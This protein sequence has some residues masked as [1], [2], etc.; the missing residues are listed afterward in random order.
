MTVCQEEE[1]HGASPA[2]EE[3][4]TVSSLVGD[5]GAEGGGGTRRA[6]SPFLDAVM[7]DRLTHR[8]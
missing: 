4:G 1:M 3:F 7:T 8:V 6:L 5:R 2:A